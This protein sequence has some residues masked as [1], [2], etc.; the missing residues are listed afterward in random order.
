M[1]SICPR[2]HSWQMTEPGLARGC[3]RLRNLNGTGQDHIGADSGPQLLAPQILVIG[4]A[5]VP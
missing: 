4:K 2:S 5:L 1:P 3:A